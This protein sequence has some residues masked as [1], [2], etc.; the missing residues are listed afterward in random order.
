[1]ACLGL[2]PARLEGAP[3]LLDGDDRGV[4]V[5]VADRDRVPGVQCVLVVS[6]S[7]YLDGL[8]VSHSFGDVEQHGR[9]VVVAAAIVGFLD[10]RASR[11]TDVMPVL[12]DARGDRLDIDHR[13][14]PVGAEQEQIARSSL[15]RERVDVDVRV[16]T[17]RT[18]DHRS[19]RMHF[20]FFGGELAA[21]Y[22]LC[23]ERVVVGQLFERTSRRRYARIADMADRHCAV[24]VKERDRH[25][26]P[27]PRGGLVE[28][29]LMHAAVRFLDQLGHAALSVPAV[30]VTAL[31]QRVRRERGS[32]FAR[33]GA[34]HPVRHRKQRRVADERVLVPAPLPPRIRLGVPL[35][36]FHDSNR[37]SVSPIRTTSPGARR[38]SRVRRIPL[39]N[40]PFVEPMSST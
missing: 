6:P 5:A 26:R 38:R 22:E 14:E 11:R 24:L 1:M 15:K 33:L 8:V 23:D 13:R 29:A 2:G 31:L 30:A 28:C 34:A 40:V 12:R 17:E 10:Q 18:C 20:G 37:R 19:L 39:T 9:D 21:P 27:H 4:A 7:G 32:H 36:D 35:A 3:D 16:G 25:R